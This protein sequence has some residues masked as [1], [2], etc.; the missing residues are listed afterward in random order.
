M[1]TLSKILTVTAAAAALC[2]AASAQMDYH[3]FKK[4]TVDALNARLNTP[5]TS[6]ALSILAKHRDIEACGGTSVVSMQTPEGWQERLDA[7]VGIDGDVVLPIP[8]A[9]LAPQFP[10]LYSTLGVEGTCEIMFDVTPEGET[11]NILPN[12]TL[13]KFAAASEAMLSDL[14]FEPAQGQTTPEM[15]NILLPVQYCLADEEAGTG[16]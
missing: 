4:E 15:E 8:S 12:C 1:Q 14:T 6:E 7:S 11:V 16:E 9:A 13:A 2:G 3:G 5:L 10:P